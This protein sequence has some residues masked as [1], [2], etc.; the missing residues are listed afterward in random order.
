MQP[1]FPAVFLRTLNHSGMAPVATSTAYIFWQLATLPNG[2]TKEPNHRARACH[3]VTTSHVIT[4][5]DASR[6]ARRSE[7]PTR[8]WMASGVPYARLRLHAAR[9][10]G[11]RAF[12]NYDGVPEAEPYKY[13]P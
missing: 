2:N 3:H 5:G 9:T 13:P 12:M 4:D 10:A 6:H 8:N 7:S 1:P 11:V